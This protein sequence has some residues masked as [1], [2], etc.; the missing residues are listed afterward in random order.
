MRIFLADHDSDYRD[1]LAELLAA[2]GMSVAVFEDAE[3]LKAAV[4]DEEPALILLG[5][6]AQGEDHAAVLGDVVRGRPC[7][8]LATADQDAERI[9]A[10]ELGADDVVLKVAKPREIIAR[11]HAVLRRT[12][13]P[14]P[15]NTNPGRWHFLPARR[16]LRRPDG[17]SVPLTT[18]EFALLDTL[19]RNQGVPIDRETLSDH[20]LGRQYQPFDRAIDTLVAKLRSKLEVDPKKPVMIRT[21]RPTG[22]VFVGFEEPKQQE[23]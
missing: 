13:A 4:A 12:S 10:F 3:D 16:V 7:M 11:V 2:E 14:T 9:A 18:A 1:Q 5:L 8:V 17:L 22:Y 6:P 20:V 21:V 19:V 15:M 23:G